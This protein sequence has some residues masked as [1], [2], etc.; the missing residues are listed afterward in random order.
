MYSSRTSML[1][2]I[3]SARRN[4]RWFHGRDAVKEIH[5]T[6]FEHA[7]P[8]VQKSLHLYLLLIH[9][10]ER[11]FGFDQSRSGKLFVIIVIIAYVRG[12]KSTAFLRLSFTT[13]FCLL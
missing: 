8:L 12:V 6:A 2:D 7:I 4:S 9:A 13:S 3:F 11:T 5:S 1:C 10:Q